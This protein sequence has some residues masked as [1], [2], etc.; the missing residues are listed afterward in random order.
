MSGSP[1]E[2]HQPD[3][4]QRSLLASATHSDR[5]EFVY[6]YTQKKDRAEN[7]LFPEE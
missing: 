4:F 7:H 1:A 3:D 2:D 6:L 5:P